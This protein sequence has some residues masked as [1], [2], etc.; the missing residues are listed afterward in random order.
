MT[1]T[2]PR[3]WSIDRFSGLSSAEQ[4]TMMILSLPQRQPQAACDGL[5]IERH[6]P[7]LASGMAHDLENEENDPS[8]AYVDGV[9]ERLALL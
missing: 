4:E 2:L 3:S 9:D 8:N 1:T 5:S 6:A 7:R